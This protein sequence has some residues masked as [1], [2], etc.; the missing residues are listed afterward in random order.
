MVSQTP[1]KVLTGSIVISQNNKLKSILIRN[2]TR[3][4][5]FE[6]F[7][8][9]VKKGSYTIDF[10]KQ[11]LLKYSLTINS[12]KLKRKILFISLLQSLFV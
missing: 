2:L 5:P 9:L 8:I 12:I 1:L 4:I 10:Q 6:G 11:K 7:T 3:L